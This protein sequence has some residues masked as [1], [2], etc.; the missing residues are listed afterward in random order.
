MQIVIDIPNSLYANLQK[1]QNGSIACKRILETVK[2]GVVLP[3][4]HSFIAVCDSDFEIT[5]GVID[6]L[7]NTIF[8]GDEE[9]SYCFEI[10]AI[11][12]NKASEDKE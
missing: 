3:T 10:V 8:V 2:N 5:E 6:K 1:I 11:G 9:C 7:K 12:I 4:G